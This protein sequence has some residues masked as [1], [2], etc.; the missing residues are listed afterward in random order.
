MALNFKVFIPLL[1]PTL[2]PLWLTHAASK[3]IF[4]HGL[5][6]TEPALITWINIKPT[7]LL[8][9][10]SLHASSIHY[11]EVTTILNSSSR[12]RLLYKVRITTRLTNPIVIASGKSPQTTIDIKPRTKRLFTKPK[13]QSKKPHQN[14]SQRSHKDAM[15]YEYGSLNVIAPTNA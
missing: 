10:V 8:C 12:D 6:G 15:A 3:I 5:Y 2:Q 11:P 7:Y 13:P 1:W 14:R 4:A 9:V